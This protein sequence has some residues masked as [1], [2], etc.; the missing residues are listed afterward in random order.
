MAGMSSEGSTVDAI[1]RDVQAGRASTDDLIEAFLAAS[2]LVPSATEPVEATFTP[3]VA[4]IGTTAYLV[5]ATT[6]ASL[7]RTSH[8][9]AYSLALAGA[10]VVQRARPGQ[11]ILVNTGED[12]F[13]IGPALAAELRTVLA[14]RP[15]Q[16]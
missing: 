7:A 13:D 1:A 9:A 14:R 5:V 6:P 2:V 8:L 3:V 12:A 15:D 16:G 4:S 11:G 10:E